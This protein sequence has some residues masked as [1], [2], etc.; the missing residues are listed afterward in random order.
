LYTANIIIYVPKHRTKAKGDTKMTT[1]FQSINAHYGDTQLRPRI[2]TSLEKAGKNVKAL[3]REDIFTFDEFHIR[4]REATRDL[5]KLAKLG[6]GDK[7]LDLGCGLGGPA[8]TLASEFGCDVIGIDL[9]EEYVQAAQ[10][11]SEHLG[12][13]GQITFRQGNVLDIPFDDASFDVVMAQ[14]VS[15]NVEDKARMFAEARRVLRSNGRLAVYE[16]CAGPA[17]TPHFPVP[18]ASNPEI[19]FLASAEE[20]HQTI[21]DAGFNELEWKDVSAPSLEWFLAMIAASQARP[22]DAPP[23]LGLNVIMGGTTPEKIKNLK[24]NLEEDRVRVV[25]GVFE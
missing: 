6:K 25:M 8:R 19:N 2:L 20:L 4:G 1:Y 9:T 5:A 15:M 23:P 14:H 11:L 3:T 17:G 24:L 16:I 22:A 18:W 12:Q 10:M 21:I 13:N 7:A